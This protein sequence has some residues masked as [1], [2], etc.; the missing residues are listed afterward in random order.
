MGSM[1]PGKMELINTNLRQV[2]SVV[3][4]KIAAGFNVKITQYLGKVVIEWC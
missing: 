1:K 4:S 2:M 3:E